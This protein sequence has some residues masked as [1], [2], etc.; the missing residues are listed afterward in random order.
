MSTQ[1]VDRKRLQDA[2]S[3]I[4]CGAGLKAPQIFLWFDTPVMAVAAVMLLT[5]LCHVPM[6]DRKK[7][8]RDVRASNLTLRDSN[9]HETLQ[10]INLRSWFGNAI[11]QELSSVAVHRARQTSGTPGWRYES[12]FVTFGGLS[13]LRQPMQDAAR[14]LTRKIDRATACE[15]ATTHPLADV[16]FEKKLWQH[17]L[18]REIDA[19]K[20]VAQPGQ[21]FSRRITFNETTAL[22]E[23]NSP[24]T[25]GSDL[26]AMKYFDMVWKVDAEVCQPH[27]DAFEAGGWW[28]PMDGICIV[29]EN[30]SSLHLDN[31]I[32]H[33]DSEPAVQFNHWQVCSLN[34]RIVPERV[35]SN[36]YNTQDIIEESN[37]TVRQIMLERFGLGRF[38]RES[39]A[40]EVA[41]DSCGQLY[42]ISPSIGEPIVVVEVVN[43]TPEPDGTHKIYHLRVPP[44]VSTAREG[45]AWTFGLQRSEY[46]PYAES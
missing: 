14:L 39:G 41:R 3:R 36:K 22:T 44:Y 11:S 12:D 10:M 23:F 33:H 21:A 25:D 30:P 15:G 20:G 38:I 43:S 19:K 6:H 46:F 45:V 28:W 27:I 34:G 5:E 42:Q 8:G 7:L 2:V 32:V 13:A 18:R 24:L 35:L 40:Q 37:L 9:L 26:L 16:D 29:S 31:G 1:P 4:Y 17:Q